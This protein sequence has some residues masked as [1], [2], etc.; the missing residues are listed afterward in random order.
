MDEHLRPILTRMFGPA[1]EGAAPPILDLTPWMGEE[2]DP[3]ARVSAAFLIALSSTRHPDLERATSIL[4]SADGSAA[5][6][7][8]FYTRGLGLVA[9][10][11]ERAT[12][13][14]P[15]LAARLDSSAR[16]MA[17][18][19]A[20]DDAVWEATWEAFFPEA[21]HI[22]GHEEERVAE[23]RANRVVAVTALASDPISDPGREVLFTSNVL[24][25]V[26]ADGTNVASLPY[27]ESLKR[28]IEASATEPQQ[29][30][31]D[32]PIQ[33]GVKPG[34]NE[35]LYGLRGLDAAI[36]SEPGQRRVTCL[37]SVSVTHH[38]LGTVTRPYVEAELERAGGLRNIDL[39]AVTED[40]TQEMVADVIVP[41]LS[42]RLGEE[43]AAVAATD[44][45]AVLGVDGEYGRHYSFL[46]AVAA[47]WHVAIDPA[48]RA[49]FKI[50]LD[51][52]FTQ[53]VLVQE[54]GK[55][56]FGHLATSLWGAT[57]LDSEGRRVEL[58]MIAGALVNE[59]DIG[60]GL[61][62]PDVDLPSGRPNFDE[63]VFYSVLPQAISTRAEMMERYDGPSIDG[64]ARA[65]E[66]I[67]VTGG[68]NGIRVD[69]LRRHRPFTPSFVGRAEDQAY[70][71]SILGRPGPRLA[72][73]HAAG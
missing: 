13:T 4:A 26:P 53:D 69:A 41:A 46:K 47:L 57:G 1:E 63:Y 34:A 40:D 56:M 17:V 72:Y 38:G 24:L 73:A 70:I 14:D 32:H 58:G 16:S 11:I 33:V 28:A 39:V 25:T 22:R 9:T 21:A 67:H 19:H 12:A 7:A 44:L 5:R 71:L 35:L 8:A 10:E 43:A 36:E 42:L 54:T 68:T 62:T 49:T 50:D 23:L 60:R 6:L 31:F 55:T 29:Y 52:I 37:L 65:L 51:Q 61:F 45:R 59:R 18:K 2:A 15:G 20:A 66:R 27:P 3:L 48:I 30:W 64:I